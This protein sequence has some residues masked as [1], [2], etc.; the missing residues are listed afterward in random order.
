MGTGG[1]EMGRAKKGQVE[2]KKEKLNIRISTS[3]RKRIEA[4]G[5]Q[6]PFSEEDFQTVVRILIL[7][8]IEVEE[9]V[10]RVLRQRLIG[11]KA[12]A[13]DQQRGAGRK[14]AGA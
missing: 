14:A 13:L 3:L 9:A 5:N 1:A 12:E 8:G 2:I 7:T 10:I 6:P 4:V 11:E